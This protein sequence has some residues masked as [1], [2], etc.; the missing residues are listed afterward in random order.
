MR[1]DASEQCWR[2]A[3]RGVNATKRMLGAFLEESLFVGL[4][5]ETMV[6][7]MDDLHRTVIDEKDNRA[8]LFAEVRRAFGRPLA[9]RCVPPD[10]QALARQ[11]PPDVRPLVDQAIAWF[12]GDVV[13]RS[14]QRT[15]ES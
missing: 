14:A 1:D 8:L 4:S 9:L 6:L 5:G 3:I 13:E 11:A 15:E 12:D 10:P 7:A 2:D